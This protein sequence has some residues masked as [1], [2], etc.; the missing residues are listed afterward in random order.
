MK[1]KPKIDCVDLEPRTNETAPSV[2]VESVS[3]ENRQGLF[4]ERPLP[5]IEIAPRV[6]RYRSR[7]D[8]LLFG[9]GAIADVGRQ[10]ISLAQDTLRRMGVRRT[11]DSP[12]KEW[13]FEQSTTYRR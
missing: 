8:F 13:F 11:V 2:A 9:A 1:N 5:V 3:A 12:A 10:R 4:E 6:L 7:R